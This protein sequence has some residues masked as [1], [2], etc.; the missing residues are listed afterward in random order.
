MT[1]RTGRKTR[2][3]PPWMAAILS[4]ADQQGGQIPRL[5]T[6]TSP[7]QQF[8]YFI[9]GICQKYDNPSCQSPTE[10]NDKYYVYYCYIFAGIAYN[11]WNFIFQ[12]QTAHIKSNYVLTCI[13]SPQ[14]ISCSLEYD[15]LSPAICSQLHMEKCSSHACIFVCKTYQDLDFVSRINLDQRVGS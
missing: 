10:G 8:S 4:A 9:I 2:R 14:I 6:S 11:H 1:I 7:R 3:F 15:I 5:T 13:I 12:Q